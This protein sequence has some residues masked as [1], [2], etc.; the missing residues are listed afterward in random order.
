MKNFNCN[1]EADV[2]IF[3]RWQNQSLCDPPI[4][5]FEIVVSVSKME[6]VGNHQVFHLFSVFFFVCVS[7]NTFVLL[8]PD[9]FYDTLPLIL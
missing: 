8:L 1:E 4:L 7:I 3:E 2:A 9:S 5:V 6:I